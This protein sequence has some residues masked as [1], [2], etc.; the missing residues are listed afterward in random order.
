[1]SPLTQTVRQYRRWLVPA[2][3]VLALAGVFIA[4]TS[5]NGRATDAYQW[6]VNITLIQE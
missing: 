2:A 5:L 6:L 3:V 1:M 4:R